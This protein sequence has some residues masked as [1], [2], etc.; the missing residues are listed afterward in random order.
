MTRLLKS[1]RGNAVIEFALGWALLSVIFT[2]MF[3]Y[4]YTIWTYSALEDAVQNAAKTAASLQYSAS[5]P[6]TFTT[7]VQNLVVY[8]SLTAGTRTLAPG[9]TTGNVTVD[10]HNVGGF[11]TNVTVAIQNYRVN[12]IFG[13]RTLNK[14]RVT[15]QFVGVVRP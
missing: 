13:T 12:A 8:G 3:Q 5:T 10:T 15:V 6:S 9:L 7:S 2:S 11:P 1:E 14:P 4:G